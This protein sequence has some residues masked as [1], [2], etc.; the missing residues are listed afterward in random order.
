MPCIL[1]APPRGPLEPNP[2][3]HNGVGQSTAIIGAQGV[4]VVSGRPEEY[5]EIRGS[6]WMEEGDDEWR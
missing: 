3:C 1:S 5:R 4:Y 6:E 2:E